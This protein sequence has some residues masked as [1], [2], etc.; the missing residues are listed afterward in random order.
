MSLAAL[1]KKRVNKRPP[2][3]ID[4]IYAQLEPADQ[5]DLVALMADD[6]VPA[7]AIAGALT[8]L[9]HT[10]SASQIATDRRNGWE[11]A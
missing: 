6:D 3:L 4:R 10:I 8:D 2:R 5:T 11:P 1:A 9:G 7:A